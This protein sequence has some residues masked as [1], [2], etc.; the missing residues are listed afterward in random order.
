[1][2]KKGHVVRSRE[3][4]V[5]CSAVFEKAEAVQEYTRKEI[6]KQNHLRE[7][8]TIKR[9]RFRQVKTMN[10]FPLNRMFH[11][12]YKIAEEGLIYN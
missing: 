3:H 10:P 6:N 8:I 5:A 11:I 9:K 12:D 4:I 1:M 2:L 7:V